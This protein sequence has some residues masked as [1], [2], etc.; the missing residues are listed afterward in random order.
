M[1]FLLSDIF[2]NALVETGLGDFI[3][4]RANY[5]Y[6]IGNVLEWDD[7][8]FPEAPE[9]TRSYEDFTRKGIFK[10][11]KINLRDVSLVVPRI[12]W[13]SGT[14]YDQWDGDYSAN[15]PSNSGATDVISANFYVLTSTFNVYKCIFN[16]NNAQSTEEPAG[17]D[18]TMIT[19]SDGYV[20]KYMYTIPLSSQNRFLTEDF[21]PVQ[22]AV[23]QAYYSRGE[24][25]SITIDNPGSGYSGVP[26]VTLAV[27]GEFL[28]GS[29]NSIANLRPILNSVGE[30]IDVVI[31]NP[32]ANYKTASIVINDNLGSGTSHNNSIANI[33]IYDPG[34]GYNAE[35]IANTTIAITTSGSAQPVSNAF[36]NL[37]FSSNALVAIDLLNPGTQYSTAAKNNTTAI[38]TTT[39]DLQPTVNATANINYITTAV[40]KPQLANGSIYNVLI[41]DEGKGYSANTQTTIVAQ[42]DGTGVVLTPVISPEG[43]LSDIIIEDRGFG[44]TDLNITVVGAGSNANAVANLSVED[45]DTL[46][47][48][49]ELSAIDGGLHAFRVHSGGNNY[50]QAN[51]TVIGDG[52]GFLGDVVLLN[53]AVSYITVTS[54]GAG[55][56]FA[57]VI[58]TG[59]GGNANVSAILS[60]YGG[61]GYNPVKELYA[62]AIMFTS[63][64]NKDKNHGVAVTNDYRQFGIIKDPTQFNSKRAF[65]S[66][67]GSS[68]IL[69]TLDTVAGLEKDDYLIHF[70]G[71]LQ[72]HRV[73]IVEVLPSTNQILA[74]DIDGF[75]LQ[76]GIDLVE[77]VSNTTYRLQTIDAEPEFDIFSGDILYI[78]NRTSV[79]YSEQQLVTLR[80]VIQV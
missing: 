51:V 11:K 73:L 63:T 12:N 23:T 10:I 60:P 26:E 53:N 64:I 58:I 27:D 72:E 20:W 67:S 18:I 50:S 42:G 13:V 15:F 33:R 4:R 2:H 70:H 59:D 45:L 48:V 66:V 39:G 71:D 77:S 24:V 80:T 35:V 61:H 69:A 34:A 68:C 5:Y 32:G 14:V 54:P 16:N 30:F 74:I 31:L 57:N 37:V 56:T 21:M 19:T 46:Q 40:L 6:Y 36:A 1:S 52:T 55:Y 78:D 44:Y 9:S 38:I 76:P 28:G 29:G 75:D 3:S 22:R 49:V 41:E 65:T 17:Q 25:S 43:L 47:T 7:P 8:Q 62:D 79:S